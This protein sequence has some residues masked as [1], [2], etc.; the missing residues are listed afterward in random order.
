MLFSLNLPKIVDFFLA[1]FI[2]SPEFD[3]D[4]SQT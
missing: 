2:A 4:G 3:G 1:K